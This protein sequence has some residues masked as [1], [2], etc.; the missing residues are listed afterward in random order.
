MQQIHRILLTA[1]KPAKQVKVAG[2]ERKSARS[3]SSNIS[4][5]KVHNSFRQ[6]LLEDHVSVDSSDDEDAL[7]DTQTSATSECSHTHFE[8]N[9]CLCEQDETS[10]DLLDADGE[11]DLAVQGITLIQVSDL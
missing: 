2:R 3:I 10:T 1:G 8:T 7:S 5:D 11:L 4:V 9:E 6:L